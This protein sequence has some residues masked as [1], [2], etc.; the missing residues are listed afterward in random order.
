VWQK[1]A[2][3]YSGVERSYSEVNSCRNLERKKSI[4]RLTDKL[5]LVLASIV[6]LGSEYDYILLSDGS[7]TF[8]IPS[9][10]RLALIALSSKQ[11]R[12]LIGKLLLTTDYRTTMKSVRLTK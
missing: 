7:K 6:T 10:I 4:Q 3:A 2:I 5:L 9:N 11:N 8:H 1:L 12:L